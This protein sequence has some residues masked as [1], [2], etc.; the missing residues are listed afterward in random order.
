MIQIRWLIYTHHA[1]EGN[2]DQLFQLNSAPK[3]ANQMNI[4]HRTALFHP[5]NVPHHLGTCPSTNKIQLTN[6]IPVSFERLLP[7]LC[8]HVRFHPPFPLPDSERRFDE[9]PQRCPF[10]STSADR[11]SPEWNSRCFVINKLVTNMLFLPTH[12]ATLL[13]MLY[14]AL[15]I[16]LFSTLRYV[17]LRYP[18]LFHS[19]YS[20]LLY[21]PYAFKSVRW[22]L[23][24]EMFI[25]HLL[26]FKIS[27]RKCV[28]KMTILIAFFLLEKNHFH[29]H[30]LYP[31]VTFNWTPGPPRYYNNSNLGGWPVGERFVTFFNRVGDIQKANNWLLHHLVFQLHIS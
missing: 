11:Q 22:K 28:S 19:L 29:S 5:S 13:C 16:R 2:I 21:S 3:L 27:V 10:K 20:T 4:C 24:N 15:L 17:T 18:T 1:F 31:F 30:Q 14:S 25:E 6:P 9:H 26:W 8:G 7:K 23:F 12:V